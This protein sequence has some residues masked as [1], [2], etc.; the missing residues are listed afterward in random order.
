MITLVLEYTGC[1]LFSSINKN[2]TAFYLQIK[3]FE[4]TTLY[5]GSALNCFFISDK[6]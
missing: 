4:L 6:L 5:M 1:E 3:V 2:Y